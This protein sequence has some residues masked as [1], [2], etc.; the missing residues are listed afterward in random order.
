M[1]PN[2]F[3]STLA[4][5]TAA[6]VGLTGGFL[7]QQLLA[8]RREVAQLRQPVRDRASQHYTS[9]VESMRNAA[10]TVAGS[11]TE[12]VSRVRETAK[13]HGSGSPTEIPAEVLAATLTPPPQGP[14]HA[15]GG[16]QER[17]SAA[18]IPALERGIEIA[19][20]VR[21]S[22]P[23]DFSVY[24]EKLRLDGS[25]GERPETIRSVEPWTQGTKRPQAQAGFQLWLGLQAD[26]AAE[27]WDR[28]DG[29]MKPIVEHLNSFRARLI[30]KSFYWLLSI[31]A[32]LLAAGVVAP[33]FYLSAREGGSRTGFM[34]A[35]IPL[36][37]AL[38][39]FF[40][41]ELTR[42]R[43]ADRLGPDTF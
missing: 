25:I 29:E 41:W 2:W 17:L 21:D 7:A 37:F 36:A 34:V 13:E 31:L 1:D 4:Q 8:Q 32:L 14:M 27:L 9:M 19:K 10:D 22:L 16:L 39:G 15:T 42:L 18:D 5:S 20:S 30:P 28:A 43:R 11:L 26:V 3:Y 12:I 23:A 24:A 38:L 6:I 35:F 33:L 40:A